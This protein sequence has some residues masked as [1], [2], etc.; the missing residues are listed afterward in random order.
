MFTVVVRTLGTTSEDG[1]NILVARGLNDGS[2]AL[3]GD[4]HEGMG[5]GSRLH[6]VDGDTDAPVGS[7]VE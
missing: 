6:G 3:L 5:M 7:C 2:E 1:M 4:T